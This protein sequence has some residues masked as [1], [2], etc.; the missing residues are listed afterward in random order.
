MKKDKNNKKASAQRRR[1]QSDEMRELNSQLGS[2]DLAPPKHYDDASSFAGARRASYDDDR[3]QRVRRR[4]S[5]D[6]NTPQAKATR[7]KKKRRLKK[8]VRHAIYGTLIVAGVVAIILVI[9]L[10]MFKVESINIKGNQ[11]YATKE[12]LAVLP[13]EEQKS[14][15]LADT[16]GAKAKLEENLPYIYTAQIKRKLPSTLEVQ[17]TETKQVY[18]IKNADKTYTLI[19]DNLKVLEEKSAKKPKKSIALRKTAV[20]SALAGHT[21]VLKDEKIADYISLLL[22]TVKNCHTEKVTAVY[23]QGINENFIEY[24]HRITIKLGAADNLDD[25]LYAAMAAIDSL[26]KTNP[27]AMGEITAKS[28]KQI[29]F[30]EK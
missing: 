6:Y 14:L 2:F 29:Y 21:V 3:Q 16:D 23:S 12:I 28:V 8:Q 24:D 22:T 30:T 5:D 20:E 11:H 27:E 13:I 4:D 9:C 17:I 19:D 26:S 1:V 18:Y 15:L 7:N 25:K 10:L